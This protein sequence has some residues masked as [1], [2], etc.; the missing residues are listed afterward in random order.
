MDLAPYLL[1]LQHF[2]IP[3]TT[4]LTWN[5]CMVSHHSP[6]VNFMFLPSIINVL[7][8]RNSLYDHSA[9]SDPFCMVIPELSY[10]Q[11]G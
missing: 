7:F 8:R 4:I 6:S 3:R 5:Y 10:F 9:F 11:T 1:P 2:D